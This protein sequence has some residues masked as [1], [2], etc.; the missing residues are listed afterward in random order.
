M[1]ESFL[2]Y[3]FVEWSY[4]WSRDRILYVR[5]YQWCFVICFQYMYVS[6]RKW[7]FRYAEYVSNLIRM[8]PTSDFCFQYPMHVS[9]IHFLFPNANDVSKRQCFQCMFPIYIEPINLVQVWIR[10]LRARWETNFA[11]RSIFRFILEINVELE[12]DS[13]GSTNDSTMILILYNQAGVL[14]SLMKVNRVAFLNLFLSRGY[15]SKT[16]RQTL[17]EVWVLQLLGSYRSGSYWFWFWFML[18]SIYLMFT[19]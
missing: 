10:T 1:Y 16:F 3:T 19:L 5:P 8:F 7:C 11:N 6:K 17:V 14:E 15:L 4:L 18:G 12:T 2:S 9:N 13:L